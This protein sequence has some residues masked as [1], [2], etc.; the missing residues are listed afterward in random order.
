M[1]FR[2]DENDT[3]HIGVYEGTAVIECGD[4]SFII[5]LIDV[6]EI[7]YILGLDFYKLGELAHERF[8]I[9]H[10]TDKQVFVLIDCFAKEGWE[11]E[12]LID[13]II[14]VLQVGNVVSNDVT[15]VG[16]FKRLVEQYVKSKYPDY[17]E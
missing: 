7:N 13:S 16:L 6:D 3:Q 5:P 9:S 4:M 11:L 1:L 12:I 15:A 10:V 17:Y 14:E 2:E 8:T